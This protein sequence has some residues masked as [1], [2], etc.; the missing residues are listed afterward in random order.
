MTRPHADLDLATRLLWQRAAE[1]MLRTLW[2]DP[3]LRLIEKLDTKNQ[4]VRRFSDT[5]ALVQTAH[6]R[7]IAHTEFDA[8]PRPAAL[9]RRMHTYGNLLYGLYGGK[10][11]VRSTV[12]ILGGSRRVPDFHEV[13]LGDE[14]LSVYRFRVWRLDQIAAA[15]LADDP[16]L[17]ALTP[18]AKGATEAD[19]LRAVRCV[20]AAF[21][22]AEAADVLG[23]LY[24]T[25]S[26]GHGLDLIQKIIRE[27]DI[28][29]SPGYTHIFNK[30]LAQGVERGIEKGIEKGLEKGIERGIE[31][32]IE[33][34]NARL[35]ALLAR[36]AAARFGDSAAIDELLQ[37][38]DA[39]AL[40]IVADQLIRCDSPEA[41]RAAILERVAGR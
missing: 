7:V 11:P 12:V 1:P 22:P 40:E 13:K 15:T 32:G 24:I 23:A 26:R 2:A 20:R 19:L 4:A 28:M 6:G 37:R 35:R 39:D 8:D 36:Q 14:T 5:V 9:T 38:C 16:A 3:T 33:R 30:G 41:L 34:A 21:N 31:T 17:A 18:L 29:L 10:Y 27:E 25:G